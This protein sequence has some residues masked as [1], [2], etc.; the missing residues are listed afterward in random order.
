[1]ITNSS[2]LLLLFTPF[3]VFH[4]SIRWWFLTGFRE[5]A[6]LLKSSGHF[7]V[8][9]QISMILQFGLS[10]LPL[11]F[12]CPPVPV[13]ILW[14]LNQEHQLQSITLSLSC[15]TVFQF[16]CK[17]HV[18]IF[19]LA[20]F[21]FYSVVSLDSKVHNFA[22]FH[23]FVII[24]RSVCLAEIWWSVCISNSQR[25]LCISFSWTDAGL[26]I[27]DLFVWSNLNFLHNSQGSSCPPSHV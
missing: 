14:W 19:L 6:S 23:F 25:S 20:F 8:F 12:P 18:L 9:W 22:S 2:L 15:F 27:Y 5:T 13:P 3:R 17:F 10:P 24:T 7:S 16:P 21:Q 4:S 11:L 26:C 1:M